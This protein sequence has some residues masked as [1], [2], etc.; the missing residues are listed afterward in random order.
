DYYDAEDFRLLKG[1][2]FSFHPVALVAAYCMKNRIREFYVGDLSR[3][4][5]KDDAEIKAAMEF[6]FQKGLV[7]YHAATQ[8]VKVKP[9]TI[10]L[11]RSFKGE[12]DYDNL[13]IHSLTDS[14]P[15]A[16][17][18]FPERYMT[19]RGVEEF[20]V[21]DSLNVRIQP[22]SSIITL[23][24]NRDIKFDGTIHAGNFEIS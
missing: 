24:Q 5:K 6:L 15:N 21:S 10:D 2:G 18:N 23:L 19:V 11:Y 13:K 17:I 7:D 9:K 16:T 20:K 22:D 3:Y 8:L 14:F 4:A 12:S 1:K